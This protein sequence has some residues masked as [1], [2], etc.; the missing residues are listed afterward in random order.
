MWRDFALEALQRNDQALA[1]KAVE[2]VADINAMISIRVDRRFDNLIALERDRFDVAAAAEA[3]V[4]RLTAFAKAHPRQLGGLIAQAQA[5]ESLG[6]YQEALAALDQAESKL[7][8]AS[9]DDLY[10]N[11]TWLLDERSRVLRKLGRTDEALNE[12]ERASRLPE[13]GDPNVSQVINLADFYVDIDRPKE[14]LRTL[15]WLRD[16]E[17]S[18]YGLQS[19]SSAKIRALIKLNDPDA[20]RELEVMRARNA[21]AF[22]PTTAVLIALGDADGLAKYYIQL[23]D[24]PDRRIDTLI[25]LQTYRDFSSTKSNNAA[26]HLKEAVLHR[27]DVQAAISKVGRIENQPVI[28]DAE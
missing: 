28:A 4:A 18:P 26:A 23:L 21:F 8:K 5:L 12:L 16:A 19:W 1:L 9:F 10:Q 3:E 13:R 14:A 17:P 27:P 7:S 11:R 24:D 2:K 20:K 25:E 22:G 6:R 15:T